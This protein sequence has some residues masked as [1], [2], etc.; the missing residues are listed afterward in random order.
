[1]KIVCMFSRES[2][3]AHA[4]H[5]YL[6]GNAAADILRLTLPNVERSIEVSMQSTGILG[7]SACLFQKHRLCYP[8]RIIQLFYDAIVGPCHPVCLLNGSYRLRYHPYYTTIISNANN[9]SKKTLA[10][11]R[12]RG[13]P[14]EGFSTGHNGAAS[15]GFEDSVTGVPVGTAR[16]DKPV[17]SARVYCSSQHHCFPKY[18]QQCDR[19]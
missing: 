19:S 12:D 15:N 9:W 2:D 14:N 1:M 16:N 6:A 3:E 11:V 13:T 8:W 4:T 5:V 10:P 17:D 18:V 7:R